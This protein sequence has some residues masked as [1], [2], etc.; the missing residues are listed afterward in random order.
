MIFATT[1][2]IPVIINL[3]LLFLYY[4]SFKSTIIGQNVVTI[5]IC[6]IPSKTL[7]FP[8]KHLVKNWG[9]FTLSLKSNHQTA[10]P[11]TSTSFSLT[12][13]FVP[14]PLGL[15]SHHRPP[16]SRSNSP[17]TT[18]FSDTPSLTLPHTPLALPSVANTTTSNNIAT[19]AI[20]SLLPSLSRL[21]HPWRY[22]FPCFLYDF[23]SLLLRLLWHS[24][25]VV[26]LE[27]HC[28][29]RDMQTL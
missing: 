1:S 27:G 26:V 29:L 6:W 13:I 18:S 17:S 10:H 23:F 20:L 25:L 22:T 5:K 15:L 8:P 24:E 19:A 7:R 3:S 28:F 2:Y 16:H 12:L 11:N 4:S 21:T 14:S 9:L